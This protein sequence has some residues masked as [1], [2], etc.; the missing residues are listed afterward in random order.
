MHSYGF[1]SVTNTAHTSCRLSRNVTVRTLGTS[2]RPRLT[3]V[4]DEVMAGTDIL[5]AGATDWAE[6]STVA[7]NID[8]PR[9]CPSAAQLIA[10]IGDMGTPF[11]IPL[12]ALHGK[13]R[14][15]L[16]FCDVHMTVEPLSHLS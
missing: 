14:L 15:I 9:W 8:D 16:H 3:S 6:T 2:L 7:D 11:E 12:S 13:S 5:R 4:L 1:V 10:N